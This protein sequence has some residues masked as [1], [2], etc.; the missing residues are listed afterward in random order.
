M[1]VYTAAGALKQKIALPAPHVTCPGFG[2]P[3]LDLLAVTTARA[4]LSDAAL[5]DAPRSGN[6]FVFRTSQR[7]Q[8][9]HVW[10]GRTQAE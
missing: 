1:A 2:G 10:A 6:L 7:G 8:P 9:T 3:D 5:Q 4:E